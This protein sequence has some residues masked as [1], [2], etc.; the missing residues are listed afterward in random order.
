[1]WNEKSDQKKLQER[2]IE[3]SESKVWEVAKTEWEINTIWY[4][5]AECLCEHSIMQNIE[6]K[7]TKNGNLA[8]VGNVCIFQ[9]LGWDLSA[10]FSNLNNIR[11]DLDTPWNAALALWVGYK[12]L[13]SKYELPLAIT[14]CTGSLNTK[15][16]KRNQ[17]IRHEYN[18]RIINK[19]TKKQG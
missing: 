5:K 8:V 12:G 3:L 6:I 4:D 17:S 9:F 18:N 1:M 16:K 15:A 14:H 11:K 10:V 19:L 2:I 7:N 13:F